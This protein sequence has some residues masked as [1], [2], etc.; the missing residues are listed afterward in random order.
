MLWL[1]LSGRDDRSGIT[2]QF[3]DSRGYRAVHAVR[4]ALG[5]ADAISFGLFVKVFAPYS[6]ADR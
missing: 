1:I 6:D 5:H 4:V 3:G 2:E